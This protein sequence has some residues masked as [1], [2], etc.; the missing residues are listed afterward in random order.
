MCHTPQI[1]RCTFSINLVNLRFHSFEI[2]L[3]FTR[4]RRSSGDGALYL[5]PGNGQDV[6]VSG[7]LY[8]QGLR[9]A[10]VAELPAAIRRYTCR[11]TETFNCWGPF[12]W[13][14]FTAADCAGSLPTGDC[15]VHLKKLVAQDGATLTNFEVVLPSETVVYNSQGNSA[16]GPALQF[17]HWNGGSFISMCPVEVVIQVTCY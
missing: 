8:E 11:A 2:L 10:K 13:V 1:L 16:P 14:R 4:C 17:K 9:V 12:D 6:H 15:D 3:K 5:A 7:P